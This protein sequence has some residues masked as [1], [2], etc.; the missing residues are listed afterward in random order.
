LY[1]TYGRLW[2]WVYYR[3]ASQF[4]LARCSVVVERF[5]V[6]C[7][8][9]VTVVICLFVKLFSLFYIYTRRYVG[10]AAAFQVGLLRESSFRVCKVRCSSKIHYRS[11]VQA[12]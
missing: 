8:V 5:N 12:G 9:V 7:F 2:V 1:R 3:L 6:D 10:V 11:C 4:V